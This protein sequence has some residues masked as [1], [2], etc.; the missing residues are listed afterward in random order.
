MRLHLGCRL[1]KWLL[2]LLCCFVLSLASVCLDCPVVLPNLSGSRLQMTFLQVNE[3]EL[4]PTCINKDGVNEETSCEDTQVPCCS[5][6]WT[7]SLLNESV[8]VFILDSLLCD[9][10]VPA[11]RN[12]KKLRSKPDS[13]RLRGRPVA[14]AWVE[15]A[16]R[17]NVVLLTSPRTN[18]ITS[19][20][21]VL[22]STNC[23]LTIWPT[24]QHGVCSCYG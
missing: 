8:A 7:V 10:V 16:R 2:L 6:G 3:S 18:V 5:G 22:Q 23:C 13:P 15:A 21:W 1:Q 9:S 20:L 12:L 24:S 4:D 14:S 11:N 17:L 19:R